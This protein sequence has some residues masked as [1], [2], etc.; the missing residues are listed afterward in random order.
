MLELLRI[1][2]DKLV[3]AGP[4]AGYFP[5]TLL[6]G[7]WSVSKLEA[8]SVTFRMGGHSVAAFTWNTILHEQIMFSATP[9]LKEAHLSNF[10]AF[11]Y[12]VS[13]TVLQ[14]CHVS[15]VTVMR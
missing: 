12:H 8:T 10:S 6:A 9:D 15:T 1:E 13:Y 14:Y 4:E 2:E 3:R 5:S 7:D 11:Q